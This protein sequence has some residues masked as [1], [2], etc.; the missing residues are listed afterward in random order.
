MRAAGTVPC[1][2]NGARASDTELEVGGALLTYRLTRECIRRKDTE[3]LVISQYTNFFM[4][5][6]S[7]SQAAQAWGGGEGGG[8]PTLLDSCLQPGPHCTCVMTA[9]KLTLWCVGLPRTLSRQRSKVYNCR[10]EYT[11]LAQE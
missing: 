5:T 2:R 11:K 3:R 6:N 9:L 8:L 10:P 7:S 1:I 4:C